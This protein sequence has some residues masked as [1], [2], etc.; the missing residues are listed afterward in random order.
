[1]DVGFIVIALICFIACAALA[2][3]AEIALFSISSVTIKTYQR[4]QK[5]RERM[6]AALALQPRQLFVTLFLVNIAGN[7]LVQNAASSLFGESGGWLLK[8]GVPLLLVVLFSELLPKYIALQN[9]IAV[10]HALAPLAQTLMRVLEPVQKHILALVTPISRAMFFFLHKDDPISREEM[11]HMLNISLANGVLHADEVKLVNGYLDL[12]DRQVKEL[13]WPRE[14]IL[15]YDTNRPL[16]KLTHLFVDKACT[17]IPV[18]EESIDDVKGMITATKYFLR[19][20]QL[21]G[22]ENLLAVLDKPFFVPETTPVRKLLRQFSER[23][24]E[25][26]LVVDEYGSIVGLVAREDLIE[27]VIGEVSDQRDESSQYTR[28]GQDIIIAGGKLELSE[29]ET[30]FGVRL[31]STN[32]M[33][34][35]GGWLTERLGDIPK[36]GT[37][38]QTA[39]FLFQVLA[40]DPNRIRRVYVRRLTP[41]NPKEQAGG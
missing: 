16:S 34:T 35:L 23:D 20:D 37:K 17:R 21:L 19:R 22:P 39:D 26:A 38:Y 29:F 24:E 32:N 36:S 12:Q 27:V 25:V 6:I 41:P 8:V 4:S 14:D 40:A 1:M 9:N 13:M 18:C 11:Q 31:E 15:F 33:L 30:I 5:P 2:S 7:I 28:A 10:A 3:A